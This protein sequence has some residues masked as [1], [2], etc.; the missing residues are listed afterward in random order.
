MVLKAQAME[1]IGNLSV[2]SNQLESAKERAQSRLNE[3]LVYYQDSKRVDDQ[4]AFIRDAEALRALTDFDGTNQSKRLAQIVELVATADNQSARQVIRDA[5]YAFAATEADLG[6]GMTNSVEAHI[7]NARR[8]LARAEQIQDRAAEKSGAQSIRTTARAVRTYGQAVNQAHTALGMIDGE[9]GPEESLTRRTDP[10]RNG[11]ERAQYTLVGNVTNPTGLDGTNVTAT[12]NDDRTVALPLR[13]GYSNGTFAGT[14]NLTERV[15]TIEITAVE[16]DDG[17]QSKN[18]KQKSKKKGNNGNGG[19]SSGQSQANTVVLRLDG[20]GL[21]DTY[22]ENVTG[23]DPLDPD[24]DAPSTEVNEADNGTID[25]NEDFDGDHLSTIRERELGTDPLYADTDGDGLPDGFEKFVIGTDPLDTDT[26]DD[27]IPDGEEDLDGDGLTNAEEYDAETSP[28]YADIDGDGLTDPQELANGTDPWQADT[29]DDGLDDGV[30]PTDPFNTDPLDPDTDEDGI[31][32]GNETYTTTA[33]NE[34]LG[35]DVKLTGEGN[36]AGGVSVGEE[37]ERF[38]GG[39]RVENMSVSEIVEIESTREFE[40]ANVTISYDDSLQAASNES[41][42][43]VVTYDPEKQLYVPIN[44][45]IDAENNTVTAETE[46][47]STF[48]VFSISNWATDVTTERP[49]NGTG[50]EETIQPVDVQFIIDSSGS[51]GWNDPQEF[52]KQAAKEFVG[53]LIPGDRAG[54]VD[55]DHTAHVAQ[56]LTTDFGA[57]N[58]TIES[59]DASGGTDIGSGVARANQHFASASNNSRAKVAILLTDGQGSGGRAQART[60]ADRNI[61]IHT[62]GFG[63]ADGNKLSDIASI[64]NGTYNY[65]EDASDLPNVFSRVAEEVE[66]KDTDGDGLPDVLEENGLPIGHTGSD[67]RRLPTN[68]TDKHTDGDELTDGEEAKEYREYPIDFVVNDLEHEYIVSYFELRSNPTRAD[69]DGDGLEDHEEVSLEN[70]SK[71]DGWN[72]SVINESGQPYRWAGSVDEN[73]DANITV[74]SNPMLKD[75]DGDG[76]NDT[77]EKEYT[78]TDPREPVTYGITAEQAEMIELIEADGEVFRFRFGADALG[79][80]EQLAT[81]EITVGPSGLNDAT[82]DFDFVTVDSLDSNYASRNR[83]LFNRISFKA[84]DGTKRTDTW[85]SNT[86]ELEEGTDPWDPDFD[87]DG[88]T[89]G[90]EL[91]GITKATQ[92]TTGGI[93]SFTYFNVREANILEEPTDPLHPDTDDDSYW[94]GWIG[95]HGVGYSD[96]GILYREHLQ[97]GDGVEGDEVVPEQA[98]THV[99]NGDEHASLHVGELQWGTD[100]TDDSDR[101]IPSPSLSVE[102]DFY[103]GANT[104]ID[105]QTWENGIERNFALY[106]IDVNVI[107]DETFAAESLWAVNPNNGF[108]LTEM[109]HMYAHQSYN[110]ED[111]DVYSQVLTY[112]NSPLIPGGRTQSGFNH[113]TMPYIGIFTEGHNSWTSDVENKHQGTLHRSPYRNGMGMTTA[114][115]LI[116]EIGHSFNLGAADDDFLNHPFRAG[117]VYSGSSDDPTIEEID[118]RQTEY[119]SV[120]RSGWGP[121]LLHHP[122]N[123]KY[124]AFSIEELT[125]IATP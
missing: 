20:D 60:A 110:S 53:A 111:A 121:D 109:E 63:G 31:K 36:V 82:S 61:T 116:H 69:S 83:E 85:L 18:G 119:W 30:E 91:K 57:V 1:R 75:T 32:D 101:E 6:P 50:G 88:L 26:D 3:S 28:Q 104:S 24:S 70:N 47:F 35:V 94:D 124:Y 123:G 49:S 76:L 105:S 90:Q 67:L 13:R 25:G 108:G 106:G 29:D 11:S 43:A 122:M 100:P 89:D 7:D 21:P 97:T 68:A 15:N 10:I 98:G 72:I 125:T 19:A 79:I 73:P 39:D 84:L 107:R 71:A 62:I 55:F 33:G 17:Q 102:V 59:L 113:L 66:P 42:L 118:K 40:S 9:V 86:R 99:W 80:P 74:T 115:T 92:G 22:E 58:V 112:C 114:K 96:D 46:H 56:E 16:S 93:A 81:E 37:T 2:P 5:E 27:G 34:S 8:Q 87:D 54:V 23:T 48:A 12:I 52:R 45:T 4:H 103:K 65:V 51:M 95:V 117:E 64:T 77:E 14:I 38:A 41:D 78:H 44:S 120:M